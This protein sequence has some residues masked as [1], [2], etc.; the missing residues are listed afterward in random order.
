MP[1]LHIMQ[2]QDP[3]VMQSLKTTTSLLTQAIQ[4]I[5]AEIEQQHSP[6]VELMLAVSRAL[7]VLSRLSE[8]L[9]V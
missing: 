1:V 7:E 4:A 5:R 9:C 2:V 8:L 3:A 6:D